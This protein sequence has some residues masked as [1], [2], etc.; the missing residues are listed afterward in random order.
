M[1]K[2]AAPAALAIALS[3]TM[4]TL[5]VSAS[6]TPA[7]A[8]GGFC[9]NYGTQ[10]IYCHCD[11]QCWADAFRRHAPLMTVFDDKKLQACLSTCVNAAEAARRH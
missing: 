5:A 11:R 3:I 2:C 10:G 4:L 6:L 1:H 7:N 9:G 8:G